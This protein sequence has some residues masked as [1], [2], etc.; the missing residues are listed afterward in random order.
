MN[1]ATCRFCNKESE[2]KMKTSFF[3]FK[4]F[5]CPSCGKVNMFP[6]TKGYKMIYWIVAVFFA[7]SAIGMLL[8]GKFGIPSILA[9]AAIASLI[10][11]SKYKKELATKTIPEI[12]K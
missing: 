9:I 3:G 12:V 6:L 11:D 8:V 10:M 1:N 5:A 2:I 4:N 7:I